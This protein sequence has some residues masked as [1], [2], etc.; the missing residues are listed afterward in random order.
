M[1]GTGCS[2]GNQVLQCCLWPDN[3]AGSLVGEASGGTGPCF[4]QVPSVSLGPT[5]GQWV[6]PSDCQ[7]MMT[8]RFRSVGPA[9]QGCGA[10]GLQLWLKVPGDGSA[11]A[12]HQCFMRC[13]QR[14]RLLAWFSPTAAVRGH[15]P[16][17]RPSAL[18]T[19]ASRATWPGNRTTQDPLP[20][21]KAEACLIQA[22]RGFG[23][24][25]EGWPL[26]PV[27]LFG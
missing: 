22:R 3:P 17:A 2:P 9:R 21:A 12:G 4:P 13:R 23:A 11:A 14:W 8:F 24:Q 1:R 26:H 10:P 27:L 19:R 25:V 18:L 7:G 16:R 6:C 5:M 15:G 20:T